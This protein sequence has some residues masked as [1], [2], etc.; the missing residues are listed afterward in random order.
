M[1]PLINLTFILILSTF[2][3][4]QNDT[5]SSKKNETKELNQNSKIEVPK[6]SNADV[7]KFADEYNQFYYEMIDATK[8]GDQTKMT[9]LQTRVVELAQ[10]AGDITQK[11][12]PEDKQKWADWAQ[13]L[14]VGASVISEEVEE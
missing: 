14:A 11:L 1:K 12:T 5:I 10:R 3:F 8:T 7:Q 4:G 13:E 6:F 9:D 2:C